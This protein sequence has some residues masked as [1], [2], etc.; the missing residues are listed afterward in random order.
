MTKTPSPWLTIIGISNEATPVLNQNAQAA[1]KTAKHLLGSK[2]QLALIPTNLTP[3]A[4][5]EE[6][7]SPMGPHIEELKTKRPTSTVIIA[8]GD[9]MCWGIGEKFSAD[10]K[11]GEIHLI[12]APSIVTLVA[13]KMLWPT[14][15]IKSLSLCSQ[16]LASLA[17]LLA[18]NQKLCLLSASNQDPQK[19]AALL[20]KNG[21]G[22]SEISI[23]QNLGS[24]NE[25]RYDTTAND[26]AAF[27]EHNTIAKLNCLAIKLKPQT[28]RPPLTIGPGLPDETFIHDGQ[29][30]KQHIRALTLMAL[31]PAPNEL[32][33][34]IGAGN[35]SISIEWLRA[36]H[37]TN[38]IA[39][40]QN[41]ARLA[42]IKTNAE[43]LGVPHLEIVEGTAPNCLDNLPAPDAI[44]IGGGITTK[45]LLPKTFAALKPT[46]RL[47]ANTVTLEGEAILIAAQKTHGGILTRLSIEHATEIGSFKGWQPTR[48]IIQWVYQK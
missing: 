4:K 42:N 27:T 45:G 16:P 25:A 36:A 44:F 15:E 32:L 22:P 20:Q 19:I 48:P 6:W 1:L 38:A 3:N 10:L 34:D 47:V 35:G 39:I 23:L 12:P 7:Q 46:G 41:S 21:Y 14:P 17:S 13:N 37:G 31:R 24:K 33:W 11:E 2:R 28:K 8:T 9:P 5:R 18:P 29:L 30:T 43:N 40:E 26:L